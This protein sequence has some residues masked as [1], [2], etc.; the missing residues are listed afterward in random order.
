[1]RGNGDIYFLVSLI[2]LSPQ[3]QQESLKQ[4][5]GTLTLLAFLKM[6]IQELRN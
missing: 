2:C 6:Q 4:P 5:E 3:G 1:V